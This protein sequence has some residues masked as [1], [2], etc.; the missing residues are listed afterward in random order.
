MSVPPRTDRE[1]TRWETTGEATDR[2]Q[3]PDKLGIAT[4]TLVMLAVVVVALA[5][6]VF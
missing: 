1:Q 5:L 2:R 4:V 3:K 6:F